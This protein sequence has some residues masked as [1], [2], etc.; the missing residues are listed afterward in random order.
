M[1]HYLMSWL[2]QPSHIAL[3]V[4]EVLALGLIP[5]QYAGLVRSAITFVAQVFGSIKK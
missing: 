3:V 1:A 4:S 2:L 5:P